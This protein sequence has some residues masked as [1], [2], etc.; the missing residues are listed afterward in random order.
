[1][2]NLAAPADG[3][4]AP[5]FKVQACHIRAAIE[6][7][8]AFACQAAEAIHEMHLMLSHDAL[9]VSNRMAAEHMLKLGLDMT[10]TTRHEL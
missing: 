2:A 7:Q 10:R 9:K 4:L 1:M 5:F 8:P 3:N 6:V